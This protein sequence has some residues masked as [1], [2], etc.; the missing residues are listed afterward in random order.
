VR[1]YPR[2]FETLDATA[3]VLSELALYRL[4][5]S[6]I[7]NFLTQIARVQPDDVTRVGTKYLAPEN[8]TIVVVGDLA[9]IRAGVEALSLGPVSVLDA[10]GKPVPAQ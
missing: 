8:L 9:K 2:R 7:G 3:G 1:G 6:E 4:P 10:D 5:D